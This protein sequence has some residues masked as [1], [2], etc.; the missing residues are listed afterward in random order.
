[1]K[2]IVDLEIRAQD[3]FVVGPEKS[4]SLPDYTT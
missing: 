2:Y 3:R 4:N 1:M